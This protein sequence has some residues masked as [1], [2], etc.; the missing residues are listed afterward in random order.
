MQRKNLQTIFTSA[1]ESVAPE[2]LVKFAVH[3]NGDNLKCNGKEYPLN[4]NV[5]V[6]G[7]GKAVYGECCFF[8]EFN[9][10]DSL[11]NSHYLVIT[12]SS[13]SFK[14]KANRGDWG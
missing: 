7:F 1:L 3:R 2:R 5:H 9:F 8:E 10:F 6:V 13:F 12:Y 4:K 14:I 11:V